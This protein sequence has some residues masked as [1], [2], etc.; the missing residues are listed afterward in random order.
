MNAQYPDRQ[1]ADAVGRSAHLGVYQPDDLRE[2]WVAG[3]LFRP[4]ARVEV[5]EDRWRWPSTRWRPNRRGDRGLGMA[6]LWIHR[7]GRTGRNRDAGMYR[8]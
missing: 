5:C 8:C 4:V 2:L 6:G 1:W 7:S 3:T